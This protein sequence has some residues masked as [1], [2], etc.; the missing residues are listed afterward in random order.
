MPD[1]ILHPEMERLHDKLDSGFRRND[2]VGVP[3]PNQWRFRKCGKG[4]KLFDDRQA[5]GNFAAIECR[6]RK[7]DWLLLKLT[8][9]M[10][11][12]FQWEDDR[13][14]ASWVIP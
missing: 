10:R 9:H 3:K 11:A 7:M 14:R 4:P 2:V 6:F 1:L 13:M 8:G 5:R 12:E